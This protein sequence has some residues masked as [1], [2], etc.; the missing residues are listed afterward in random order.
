VELCQQLRDGLAN[1]QLLEG[2]ANIE[3][4]QTLPAEWLLERYPDKASRGDYCDKHDLGEVPEQF[5]DFP[6]FFEDRK[7]RLRERIGKLLERSGSASNGGT[8]AQ[9]E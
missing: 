5:A 4:Q 9:E 8:A 1:L 6:K 2:T 3:K 7:Q